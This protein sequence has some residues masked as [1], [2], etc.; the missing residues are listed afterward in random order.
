ML[1]VTA[2]HLA[3]GE[4]TGRIDAGEA[5]A[6]SFGTACLPHSWGAHLFFDLIT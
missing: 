3:A 6:Y 1:L 5:T 4:D 2:M